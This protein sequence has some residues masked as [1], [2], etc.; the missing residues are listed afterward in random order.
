M[1]TLSEQQAAASAALTQAFKNQT[2]RDAARVAAL[3]SLYYKARVDPESP[4]SVEAWLALMI[5]RLISVS[6]QGATKAALYFDTLRRLELGAGAPSFRA[7]AAIG[8]I[9]E[10]VRKSLLSVGPYDYANKVVEIDRIAKLTEN[11]RQAMITEAKDVTAKKVAAS[12]LR[13]AQGGARQ[14]IH[15]NSE[16]DQQAIGWIRVTKADP[17]YFCAALASRGIHYRPFKEGSFDLSNARFSGEGDAKVHDECGCAL[18]AVYATNDFIL[19]QNKRF[20][21]MWSMWGAGGGDSM[22]RFR[23]GYEHFQET[24]EYLTHAE[25]SISRL[26]A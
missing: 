13:H 25:A 7:D 20:G 14:T 4:E 2:N 11:E 9:D 10:G 12:V 22:L 21:D 26:A 1:A 3:I 23:R 17:C 6:D 5:P 24:G 19:K 8:F 16:T 18:K 15:E